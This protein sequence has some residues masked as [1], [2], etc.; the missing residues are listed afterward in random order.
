MK[1][2]QL[3]RTMVGSVTP[4]I[5]RDSRCTK[6][7]TQ[8]VLQKKA[9]GVNV[10]VKGFSCKRVLVSKRPGVNVSGARGFWCSFT[11]SAFSQNCRTK[12][13]F[14]T[15]LL[16]ETHCSRWREGPHCS[17][18]CVQTTAHFSFVLQDLIFGRR[19]P[20]SFRSKT[21]SFNFTHIWLRLATL[22]VTILSSNSFT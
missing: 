3:L 18:L 16:L 1:T 10:C 2:P 14:E 17:G 22:A 19:L 7:F 6:S 21:H 8:N 11:I 9:S 13:I 20:G 15:W 5:L 12:C 4:A